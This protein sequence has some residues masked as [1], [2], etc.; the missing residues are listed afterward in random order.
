MEGRKE[1]ALLP[2]KSP[3]ARLN[4]GRLGGRLAALNPAESRCSS[5]FEGVGAVRRTGFL[6]TSA[7]NVLTRANES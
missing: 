2:D 1:D 3:P 5:C 4:S 7:L 6:L